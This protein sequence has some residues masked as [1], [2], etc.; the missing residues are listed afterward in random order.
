M[1]KVGTGAGVRVDGMV[2]GTGLIPGPIA[3]SGASGNGRIMRAETGV[4]NELVQGFSES[5]R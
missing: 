1:G 5:D 4:N 3:G 2:N